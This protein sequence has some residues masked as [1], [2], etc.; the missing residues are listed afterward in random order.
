MNSVVLEGN[1]A[2]DIY[3]NQNGRRPLLRLLLFSGQ[4]RLVT[5]LRTVL[6]DGKAREFY[7]SL[8]KG[9]EIGV[10]GHITTHQHQG[11]FVTE[12]EVMNLLLVRNFSW[13]DIDKQ[14]TIAEN[15]DGRIVV[16][17]KIGPDILFEWRQRKS[18]KYLGVNDLYAFL[19]FDLFNKTYPRGLKINAYGPFAELVFPFLCPNSEI[20]VDG[21][22]HQDNP[23]RWGVVAENMALL[24]NIDFIRAAAAQSRIAQ[25]CEIEMEEIL[26]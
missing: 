23:G 16:E 22:L 3:L 5:G 26:D 24:R 2:G 10:I 18:G 4:P 12:I 14:E 21:L 15:G 19:Q 13:V 17:G 11:H 7:G 20:V 25:V 8:R 9:S 1:I 6:L